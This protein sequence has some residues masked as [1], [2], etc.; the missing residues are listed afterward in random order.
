MIQLYQQVQ[1]VK[2]YVDT[3]VSGISADIEGVT[4]GTGLTGGQLSGT[5]TLNIDSI[6][7]TDRICYTNRFY[8]NTY[9]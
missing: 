9:K 3:Q 7:I 4:A 5:V 1:A 8:T 2:D 6:R